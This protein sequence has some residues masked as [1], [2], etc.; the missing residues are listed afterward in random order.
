MNDLH[1]KPDA[2]LEKKSRYS[3]DRIRNRNIRFDHS[4]TAERQ[5]IA[6][7]KSQKLKLKRYKTDILVF[8]PLVNS[9][10]NN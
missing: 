7:K 10:E 9:I 3:W 4:T 8:R 1:R 6:D 5:R 2:T